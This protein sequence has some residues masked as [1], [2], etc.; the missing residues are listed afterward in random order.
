MAEV[1]PG[2]VWQHVPTVCQAAASVSDERLGRECLKLY[3]ELWRL[4]FLTT[5][6]TSALKLL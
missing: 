2:E 1:L 3:T 4:V 6:Q 5:R